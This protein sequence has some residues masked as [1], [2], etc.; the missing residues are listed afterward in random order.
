[1]RAALVGA[2]SLMVGCSILFPARAQISDPSAG[3]RLAEERCAACHQIAPGAH[4]Q[5]TESKAPSF[6]DVSRMAS[7][8]ELSIKVFL[9]SSHPTMPNIMLTPDEMDSIAAYIVSLAKK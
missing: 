5:R 1:M 2:S 4:A 7:T 3:F 9:R 6:V 8:T